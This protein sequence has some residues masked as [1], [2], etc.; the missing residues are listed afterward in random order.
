MQY[1]AVFGVT[2]AHPRRPRRTRSLVRR[3]VRHDRIVGARPSAYERLE[4]AGLAP[5]HFVLCGPAI[6][7]GLGPGTPA[8]ADGD[9]WELDVDAT[10]GRVLVTNLRPRATEFV[11]RPTATYGA[12]VY[13]G[14]VPEFRGRQL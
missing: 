1:D 11:R 9:E 2:G 6:A 8:F 3:H 7:I 4:D 12:P 5:H 13:G 14:I 10:D